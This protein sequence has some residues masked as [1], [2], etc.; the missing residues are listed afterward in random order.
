MNFNTEFEAMLMEDYI[1]PKVFQDIDADSIYNRIKSLYFE[2]KFLKDQQKNVTKKV[3]D[4]MTELYCYKSALNTEISYSTSVGDDGAKYI[5]ARASLSIKLTNEKKS[6]R[7]VANFYLGDI[8]K[9]IRSGGKIDVK[10]VKH[11]GGG[12]VIEKL[13]SKLKDQYGLS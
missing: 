3:L 1:N 4:V 5:S 2:L 10:L 9:F 13:V 11:L 12:Q 8:D 6:K 7:V